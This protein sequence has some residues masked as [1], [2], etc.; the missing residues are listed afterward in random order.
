MRYDGKEKKHAV[1][2][3]VFLNRYTDK[4]KLVPFCPEVAIGLGVP[5][6]KIQLVSYKDGQKDRQK[7]KQIRVV[8]VDNHTLD[9][10][11]ELQSYAENFLLQYSDI[12]YYIVKSKSPSCG[13]QSTPLFIAQ[14]ISISDDENAGLMNKYKYCE[15][16]EFTSGLFVQTLQALK[17]ELVIIEETQLDSEQACEEFFQRIQ[18]TA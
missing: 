2:I 15:Q 12:E 3:D 7:D 8:G 4:V 10:T 16:A 11:D 9:V 13:Y 1:I 6:A 14:C 17:P 18:N 5:R